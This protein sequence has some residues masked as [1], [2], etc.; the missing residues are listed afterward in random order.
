MNS[1]LAIFM[2]LTILPNAEAKNLLE[3]K[4]Q[5]LGKAAEDIIT[6]GEAGRRR[7]QLRA[8]HRREIEQLRLQEMKRL[9]AL[10]IEQLEM[11]IA[12]HKNS[13]Q[14]L[15]RNMETLTMLKGALEG[16]VA[17]TGLLA[18]AFN[19]R[20]MEFTALREIVEIQQRD[21]QAWSLKIKTIAQETGELAGQ[22]APESMPLTQ[23]VDHYIEQIAHLPMTSNEVQED[24]LIENAVA[25]GLDA[26]I[27]LN[28]ILKKLQTATEK[29]FTHATKLEDI[30]KNLKDKNPIQEIKIPAK[31]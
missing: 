14:L 21:L 11:Q 5:Q 31:N 26:Q 27:M 22:V 23:K 20:S 10:K 7:D 15:E 2:Y 4:I 12:Q 25:A 30:L 8:K 29:E 3:T 28:G 19:A 17:T 1:A 24:A 16:N 18:R 6:I 9:E 13:V